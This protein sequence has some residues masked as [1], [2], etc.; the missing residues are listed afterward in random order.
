[1]FKKIA[2]V[3]EDCDHQAYSHHYVRIY[4]KVEGAAFGK[5]KNS[6]KVLAMKCNAASFVFKKIVES[7][8]VSILI[9]SGTLSPLDA[10]DQDLGV[11]FSYKVSC[12]HVIKQSQILPCVLSRGINN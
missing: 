11:P 2:L 10:L 5:K 6:E 9:T 8:P 7:D 1:M 4:D 3:A 12:K